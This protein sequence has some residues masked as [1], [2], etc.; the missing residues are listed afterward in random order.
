MKRVQF[1]RMRGRRI[2]PEIG[3]RMA[4]ARWDRYHAS[5]P[6]REPR[7]ER[8]FPMELGMRDKATG[9]TAWVDFRGLR[10]AMRRLTVVRK[11]YVPGQIGA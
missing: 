4:R 9:E 3:R 8:W 5:A 10:D 7:F 6:E 1:K 11:F 2:T